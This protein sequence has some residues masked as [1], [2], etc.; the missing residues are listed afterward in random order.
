MNNPGSIHQ[1]KNSEDLYIWVLEI[2]FEKVKH[3]KSGILFRSLELLLK[4]DEQH[5][6]QLCEIFKIKPNAQTDDDLEIINDWL[7]FTLG[8]AVTFERLVKKIFGKFRREISNKIK[9]EDEAERL[10]NQQEDNMV[11]WIVAGALI[12]VGLVACLKFLEDQQKKGAESSERDGG[13][14]LSPSTHRQ[15]PVSLYLVVPS[16]I[17]AKDTNIERDK[18]IEKETLERLIDYA[19]YF[20][21]V[22]P[23]VNEHE[24][25]LANTEELPD[26]QQEVYVRI[27]ISDGEEMLDKRVPYA[28]KSNLKPGAIFTIR[29]ISLLRDLSD[30]DQFNRQFNRI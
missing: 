20:L 3:E 29:K 19:S 2:V 27:D 21:C 13:T 24:Q 16:H 22:E 28:L 30:L 25:R 26:S 18:T 8:K 7:E 5:R 10:V 6:A 17:V 1:R 4:N 14:G 23:N 9:T 12:L 15:V 11:K